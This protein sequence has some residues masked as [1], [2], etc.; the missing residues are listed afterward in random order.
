VYTRISLCFYIQSMADWLSQAKF[1]ILIFLSIPSSICSILIL[2]Y[3]YRQRR[4]ILIHYHLVFVLITT[5]LLEITTDISF[6]INYYQKGRV[7]LG[8]NI[9]CTWWN[10]WKYSLNVILLFVMAW[11]SIERHLLVFHNQIMAT[12]RK[13]FVFHFLPMLITSF[14]PPIFYFIFIVLSSC[15]N[16]WNYEIVNFIF[17]LKL[18][19]I[20]IFIGFMFGAMLFD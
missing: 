4:N 8:S 19:F 3:F 5:S 12:K 16:Q 10:W 17:F 11:G 15:S 6:N 20:C 9:F 18:F 14:Y 1:W 7:I 2:I 13:R